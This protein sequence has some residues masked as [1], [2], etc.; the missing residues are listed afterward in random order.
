[1]KVFIG[2][3]EISGIANGLAIGL[4]KFNIHTEL[5]T[6]VPHPFSYSNQKSN[7]LIQLWQYLFKLRIKSKNLLSK[8]LFVFATNIYSLV[9]F[10]WAVKKFDGFIFFDQT[11]TNS[12]LE[13]KLLKLLSKKIIFVY[14]GSDARPPFMDGAIIHGLEGQNLKLLVKRIKRKKRKIRT[15]EKYADYVINAPATS[16]FQTKP[17]INWFEIGIPTDPEKDIKLD[18]AEQTGALIILHCPSHPLVKGSGE[19]SKVI[20]RLKSSG[21]P[22]KYITLQGVPNKTVLNHIKKAD[23]VIDQLYSD[24]PMAKFASEAAS[25]GKPVLVSGY[26]ADYVAS[27]TNTD[28]YPPLSC[29]VTPENFEQKLVELIE[30]EKFRNQVSR[31]AYNFVTKNWSKEQVCKRYLQLLRDDVPSSWWINPYQVTY[32]HGCGISKTQLNEYWRLL[33]ENFGKEAFC[34]DDK[35]ELL[36]KIIQESGVAEF[37]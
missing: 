10:F 22:I 19:I 28:A 20:E 11:I 29:F 3:V 4:E 24:T 8:L 36:K 23:I 14:T 5:V 2:P 12:A 13:L 15:Q 25:M 35:P 32:I 6:K 9:V 33:I 27:Q 21:H 30:S 37:D 18:D 26:F 31:E 16:Q 17:F 7:R 1:M 34:L